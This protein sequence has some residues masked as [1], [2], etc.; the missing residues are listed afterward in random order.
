MKKAIVII[1]IV[2]NCLTLVWAQEKVNIIDF[3]ARAGL[4]FD[5]TKAV[6]DAINKVYQKGGGVV[7]IPAGIYIIGPIQLKSRVELNLSENTLLLG[8]TKRMDY[9]TGEAQALISASGQEQVALTGKGIIDGRGAE[10][11]KDLMKQLDKG[12]LQ[13]PTWTSKRPDEKNRPRLLVIS[14]TKGVRVTGVTFK[15]SA[16]WVQ[17]YRLCEDVVIDDVK[18]N[19]T[20]YWNND[21]IDIVNCK[22]VKITNCDIDAA[23]DAI[24][25]KSEGD[26]GFCEDIEVDNCSMR[27]SASG[28]KIGTG[29]HGGFKNIKVSNL[30]VY[31]TFRSAIALEAVDGGFIE[32]VHIQHVKAKNVGNAFFIR[33][34]HRNK[35]ERY[36]SI[37][38]IIIE[39]L[40][41]TVPA[42]KPDVGYPIEGP[43]PKVAPH[44]L[45]PASIT[46]I[47]KHYVQGVTLKDIT[48]T[49]GGGAD[50]AI[51][52]ISLDQLDQVNE[53]ISG[54]PE[55]SMFG[56]L[57]AWGLYTRHVES[58][59]LQNVNLRFE[60]P[61]F[62]P[63][64]LFDDVH[65]AQLQDMHIPSAT[66]KAVLYFYKCS[67]IDPINATLPY[68]KEEAIIY[69][70]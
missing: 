54:Y 49:Y 37:K 61:D 62:R 42:K 67:M 6:Q 31:N 41:A 46:G 60:A 68:P 50:S 44:N 29:S 38:N 12:L 57:P 3:G 45:L 33:L 15:N 64:V 59:S 66:N 28:F 47:P 2:T 26:F 56:E 69:E 39:D 5:N 58:L 70:Q 36:S 7:H 24:C 1:A 34:G 63:S 10:L 11:V 17:D 53:N 32:N 52:H 48:I 30:Y 19:S 35:D 18:V 16:G 23:D 14:N 22:R 13:D 27:S 51:A 8:S 21:G 9:G 65:K 25:L 55:F 20:S 43:L 40:Q 4:V